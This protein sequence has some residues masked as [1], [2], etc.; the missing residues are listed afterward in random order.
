[1]L[2]LVLKS[3]NKK[4]LDAY[5]AYLKIA[6]KMHFSLVNMPNRVKKITLL[7]SPHVYKKA[8]AQYQEVIYTTTVS[9]TREEAI[10]FKLNSIINNLPKTI[11]LKV[12]SI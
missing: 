3:Y 11:S 5:I 10:E 2:H 1:M 7:R 12:I 6:H 9:F 4:V 8:K